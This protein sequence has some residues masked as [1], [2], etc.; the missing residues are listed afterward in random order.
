MKENGTLTKTV[1]PTMRESKNGFGN[2][3]NPSSFTDED[4]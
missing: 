1:W 2:Y 3:R 4:R